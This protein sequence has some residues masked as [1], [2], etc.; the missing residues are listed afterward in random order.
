MMEFAR[1]VIPLCV[2][3]LWIGLLA[4][5]ILRIFGIPMAIGFWRLDRLNQHLSTRQYVWGLGVFSFGI[6]LLLLTGLR[7]YL[8]WRIVKN[9]TTPF[10]SIHV[11]SRLLT[12]IFAGWIIGSYGAAQAKISNRPV[13]NKP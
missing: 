9:G 8:D 7:E 10:T 11:A 12:W 2:A 5:I 13:A 4:P 6:G 3:V 1:L